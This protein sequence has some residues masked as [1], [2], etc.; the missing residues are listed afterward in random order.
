MKNEEKQIPEDLDYDKVPNLASEAREKLIKA[1]AQINSSRRHG[2]R[3]YNEMYISNPKVMGV[4]AY[5]SDDKVGKIQ[6]FIQQEHLGFLRDYATKNNIPFI[7]FG[8]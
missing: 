5:A 8:D 6:N 7:V 1:M 2:D 3:S 4:F